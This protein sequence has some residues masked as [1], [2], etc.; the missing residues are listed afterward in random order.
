MMARQ[1]LADIAPKDIF[2][3]GVGAPKVEIEGK[4]GGVVNLRQKKTEKAEEK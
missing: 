2:R 3:E 4:T 1:V